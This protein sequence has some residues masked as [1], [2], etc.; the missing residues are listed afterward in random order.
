MRKR[1][2]VFGAGVFVCGL[3]LSATAYQIATSRETRSIDIEFVSLAQGWEFQLDDQ[4]RRFFQVLDSIRSLHDLSDQISSQALEEFV[5][6]GM[7]YQQEILGVFGFAQNVPDESRA[8]FE[9]ASF[10]ATNSAGAILEFTENKMHSASNRPVYF[11]IVYQSPD[12]G[13]GLPTGFDLTSVEAN[14]RAIEKLRSVATGVL[15]AELISSDRQVSRLA[16]SP[17]VAQLYDEKQQA[18]FTYVQGV[19]FGIFRPLALL[20]SAIPKTARKMVAAALTPSSEFRP[21]PN[22]DREPYYEASIPIGDERWTFSASASPGY[23]ESHRTTYPSILLA[24]SMAITLLLTLLVY[25]LAGRN[26]RTEAIVAERTRQLRELQG[27][28]LR[29]SAETQERV[30]R[31]LH[32]SLGQKL[33]GAVF[34]SRAL[35][36]NDPRQSSET[37]GKLTSILKECVAQVRM[38]ARGLSPIDFGE[39]GLSNA[40]RRLADDSTDV[41]SV[42]CAFREEG[43]P[44]VDSVSAAH[45]YHIA[46]EAVTNAIRH[47]QA[48]EVAIELDRHSL[49]ILDNGRGFDVHDVRSNGSGLRIMRHR[50]ET[51]GGR[52]A[53]E[54]S[55]G[56]TVITCAIARD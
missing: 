42:A 50:A 49:R 22:R 12:R 54:S 7:S 6:K 18:Y 28:V 36:P 46:Q 17:I 19:A 53:V 3:F 41:F 47:G 15:G 39:E 37:L 45:L 25:H 52:L 4:C 38:I 26:E 35:D 1:K 43:H 21:S 20:D 44:P 16:F 2:H 29:V 30:G 8:E 51:L 40:L 56:R 55:P 33:A 34:L 48:S 9:R 32:D 24:A 11:P 10:G 27:E 23:R 31:D 5:A 14:Q 13:S